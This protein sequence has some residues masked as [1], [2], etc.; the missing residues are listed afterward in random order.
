[1]GQ[2]TQRASEPH[3]LNMLL[4]GLQAKNTGQLS[5]VTYIANSLGCIA[6]IFTS[7][8]EGGGIAMIRGFIIGELLAKAAHCEQLNTSFRLECRHQVLHS[9]ASCALPGA[10]V[11]LTWYVSRLVQAWC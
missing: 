11:S 9:P 1:M 6:R 5:S 8:Q 3:V 7:H 4:A 10:H 2:P